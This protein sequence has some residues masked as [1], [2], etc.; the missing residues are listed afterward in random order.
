MAGRTRQAAGG[1]GLLNQ[2]SGGCVEFTRHHTTSGSVMLPGGGGGR[3]GRGR[4][5]H[6]HARGVHASGVDTRQLVRCVL[7]RHRGGVVCTA[8]AVLRVGRDSRQPRRAPRRAPEVTR[9][10]WTNTSRPT[11]RYRR[12]RG[13]ACAVTRAAR[14]RGTPFPGVPWSA[15]A[16]TGVSLFPMKRLR[17]NGWPNRE[18][19]KSQ[20]LKRL[21]TQ[22]MRRREKDSRR[23]FHL[24]SRPA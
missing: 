23:V 11:S 18:I 19:A 22:L 12:G 6:G 4:R 24:D 9:V 2:T 17:F 10:R 7:G 20:N 5:I 1:G 8:G 3:G 14:R 15:R 16:R 13:M 21:K